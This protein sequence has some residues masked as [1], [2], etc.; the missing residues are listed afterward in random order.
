MQTYIELLGV[1]MVCTVL[2]VNIITILNKIIMIYDQNNLNK[3][4]ILF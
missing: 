2:C 3:F 4:E 1:R